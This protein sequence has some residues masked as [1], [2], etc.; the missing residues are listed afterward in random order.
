V[1]DHAMLRTT[2]VPP[3]PEPVTPGTVRRPTGW[4]T[5]GGGVGAGA[6]SRPG[7]PLGP[8]GP[9]GSEPRLKSRSRSEWSLTS[10]LVSDPFS[11]DLPVIVAVAYAEPP[12]TMNRQS[13]ETTLA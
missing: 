4:C 6:P 9:A 3:G 11:T 10:A 2:I 1:L 5:A 7:S 12:S 8:A 13:V